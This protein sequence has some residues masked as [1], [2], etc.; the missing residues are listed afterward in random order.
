MKQETLSIENG[1][2][3]AQDSVVRKKAELQSRGLRIPGE[4]IEE[5]EAKHN[6]PA[7]RTGRIVVCLESPAGNGDL[8]PVFIVNGK[9]GASSH[10]H[11]VKNDVDRFEVWAGNEK[12]TD[13]KLMPRPEFYDGMTADGTPRH[14]SVSA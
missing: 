4:L 6:A 10:L 8:I 1:K 14:N 2:M 12:Y 9:R 7:V 13:V 3:N 11:L 5:L